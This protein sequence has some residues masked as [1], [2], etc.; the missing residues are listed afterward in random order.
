[1]RFKEYLFKTIAHGAHKN[2][3][4]HDV[5]DIIEDLLFINQLRNKYPGV[6]V[7]K[8]HQY[9]VS[10]IHIHG[11]RLFFIHAVPVVLFIGRM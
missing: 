10:E 6:Q 1:M 9:Q 5:K 2:E 8:Y 7:E 3:Y 11:P 4:S